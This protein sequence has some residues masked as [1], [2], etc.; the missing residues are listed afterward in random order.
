[1]LWGLSEVTDISPLEVSHGGR[2]TSSSTGSG[3]GAGV[4][5]FGADSCGC[6]LGDGCFWDDLLGAAVSGAG[7]WKVGACVPAVLLDK[8]LVYVLFGKLE[9]NNFAGF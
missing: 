7:G 6:Y 5:G 1:M 8:E 9:D 3:A 4:G 2:G